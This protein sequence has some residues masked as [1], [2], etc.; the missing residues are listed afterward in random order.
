[1]S[2]IG[3]TREGAKAVQSYA[4]SPSDDVGAV[5]HSIATA[6]YVSIL[7]VTPEGRWGYVSQSRPIALDLVA[8]Y[9]GEVGQDAVSH[10][11]DCEGTVRAIPI[12]MRHTDAGYRVAG[13]GLDQSLVD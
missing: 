9:L 3:R 5:Y 8:V 10:R 12:V 13:V 1:M 2:P 6:D 11:A 7:A 4:T